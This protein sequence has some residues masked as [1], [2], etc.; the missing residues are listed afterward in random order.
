MDTQDTS[1]PQ[2]PG[3][4]FKSDRYRRTGL[5]VLIVLAFIFFFFGVI[6]G[7][8]QWLLPSG[9]RSS[10]NRTNLPRQPETADEKIE[11]LMRESVQ[12]E[13]EGF[14]S[15]STDFTQRAAVLTYVK[16]DVRSKRAN[17]IIWETAALDMPLYEKD[18]IQTS[19]RSAAVVTFDDKNF[20]DVSE[21][22]LVI[23][24]KIEESRIQ[25][26]KR[27]FM[28]LI[29]GNLRGQLEA[30]KNTDVRL[31]VTTPTAITEVASAK[32]AGEE[33]LFEIS[34]KPDQT[35]KIKVLRGSAKV[36]AQG[37]EV[38]VKAHQMTEVA[39]HQPPKD[40]TTL[41]KAVSLQGPPARANFYYADFPPQIN[42]TWTPEPSAA[43]YHLEISQ[44]ELFRS[45]V[46]E[47]RLSRSNFLY[48]N[49]R[50]GQYYW[51]VRTMDP[52]GEEGEPSE[53]RPLNVFQYTEPPVLRVLEPETE[54]LIVHQERLMVSG[55]TE[56]EVKVYVNGKFINTGKFGRFKK[57][58]P[59]RRGINVILFESID[60]AGNVA[61]QTRVVTN[62]F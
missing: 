22:S 10:V 32:K 49:L 23:I 13:G 48:G 2:I 33:S 24:K 1:P 3:R 31:L 59:L 50:Q 5:Q 60:K 46:F 45:V 28:V 37:K 25:Q 47:E 15:S 44:D 43:K 42:F 6:G 62:K 52:R 21:N 20:L 36:R 58:V 17:E 56:P 54:Q 16:N 41:P 27:S 51:R 9:E 39:I 18:A 38:E 14:F 40:P 55:L 61:Y 53:A 34:V 12:L 29:D 57:M 11:K 26:E 7:V 19:R 35:S 4:F 8:V 30:N